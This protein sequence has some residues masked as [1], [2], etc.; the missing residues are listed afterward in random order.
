MEGDYYL[1]D[2]S[3]VLDQLLLVRPKCI[4]HSVRSPC[5]LSPL[6]MG[7]RPSPTSKL[8]RTVSGEGIGRSL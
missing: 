6:I 5:S 1:I 2:Q 7:I 8:S 3:E 4:E